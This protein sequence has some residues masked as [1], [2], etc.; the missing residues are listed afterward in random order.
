M[1]KNKHTKHNKLYDEYK[2]VC[3][4]TAK[5]MPKYEIAKKRYNNV[6]R[7]YNLM[8]DLSRIFLITD[9]YFNLHNRIKKLNRWRERLEKAEFKNTATLSLCKIPTVIIGIISE[10]L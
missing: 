6:N 8:M 2:L 9:M 1:H 10:Y 5:I 4:L 3:H 7:D